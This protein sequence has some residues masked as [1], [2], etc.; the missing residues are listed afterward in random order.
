MLAL[1]IVLAICAAYQTWLWRSEADRYGDQLTEL[2][3]KADTCDLLFF[4]ES[5]NANTSPRDSIKLS[6]SKLFAAHYPQ[7]T[8]SAVD[9]PAVHGGVFVALLNRLPERRKVQTII[10]TMNLRSFGQAWIHSQLESQLMKANVMYANPPLALNKWRMIFGGYDHRSASERDKLKEHQ[11]RTDTLRFPFDYPYHTIRA[12]DDG[13]GNGKYLHPDGSWDLPK[14]ALACHYIKAYA[15]QIDT[16]T[17]PRIHDFDQMVE[18]AQRKKVRLVFH[19]MAENTAYADSLVGPELTFLMRQNRD[20]LV[21]RYTRKGVQVVDQLER[22]P[23]KYY[24][25]Q[26]WTTEHYWYEGRKLLADQLALQVK[27]P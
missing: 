2:L 11:W 15:F 5:S 17:N 10:V 1:M 24:T 8:I 21:E 3:D 14:I 9:K 6:I 4:T 13:F 7:Y 26:N 25:D 22:V 16:L 20:L 23:G 27:I 12:W 18:I 19:L